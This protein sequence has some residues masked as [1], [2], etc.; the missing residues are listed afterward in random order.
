ML[1]YALLTSISTKIY[2]GMLLIFYCYIIFLLK[3]KK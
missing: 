1:I 3:V 2:K